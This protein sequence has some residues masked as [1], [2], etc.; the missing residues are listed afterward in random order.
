M[1]FRI[2]IEASD[3]LSD[4]ASDMFWLFGYF[5]VSG[6]FT[7]IDTP[8]VILHFY[9]RLRTIQELYKIGSEAYRQRKSI[10]QHGYN[11]S[12]S[13]FTASRKHK[14]TAMTN[15]SSKQN[16]ETLRSIATTKK[17][18]N[19]KRTSL[20]FALTAALFVSACATDDQSKTQQG[21]LIGGLLGAVAG[22]VSGDSKDAVIGAVAG[23][24]VGGAVGSYQDKQQRELE[25][26]L[27]AEIAAEQIEIQRLEDETLQVSLSNT[28]SFDVNSSALKPGFLP[29]LDR[30]AFLMQKYDK[31]AVHVIGHTDSTG[32]DEFNENLSRQ[33]ASSVATYARDAGL[34][35]RRLSVE[36]RGEYEPRASN[37]TPE[38]RRSNRRVEIFLKPIVE[39]QQQQ[40]FESPNYS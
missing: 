9:S 17:P 15:I 4:Y 16:S 7:H 8:T 25:E 20:A 34:N 29:A 40:A 28:A 14:R 33:R 19:H 23:A 22:A 10:K 32:S 6:T 38:G 12:K 18:D 5:L 24:L 36:G 35:Q 31:T 30:L 3:T 39:G 13:Q 26:Q 2:V 11:R 21:A 27:A 37:D 1:L